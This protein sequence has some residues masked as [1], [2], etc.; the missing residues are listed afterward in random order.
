MRALK[1]DRCGRFYDRA[2]GGARDYD[3]KFPYS[4]CTLDLCRYCNAELKEWFE[5]YN[6]EEADDVQQDVQPGSGESCSEGLCEVD[7]RSE[8]EKGIDD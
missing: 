1:C 5:K 4:A 2:S 7:G 3:I 8:E 6:L